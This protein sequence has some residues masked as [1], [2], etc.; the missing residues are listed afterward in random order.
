MLYTRAV[1][2]FNKK[3]HFN[4]DGEQLFD[5]VKYVMQRT[6]AERDAMFK[7]M[8]L[9]N[10]PEV[11]ERYE[12]WRQ[13]VR[14][15]AREA[16]MDIR[17]ELAIAE[18]SDINGFFA[19]YLNLVT[20]MIKDLDP[21]YQIKPFFGLSKEEVRELHQDAINSYTR[22]ESR[23]FQL[24][25]F[26]LKYC[27]RDI[28]LSRY[29]SVR[30]RV[31]KYSD[32]DQ[33]TRF[34][35]EETYISKLIVQERLES[36]G[37]FWKLFHPS[38][39]REMRNFIAAAEQALTDVEFTEEGKRAAEERYQL[40][41][42]YDDEREETLRRADEAF[43]R[44]QKQREAEQKALEQKPLEDQLFAIGFKPS[45]DEAVSQQQRDVFNKLN[46]E[47]KENPDK[48]PL[49]ARDVFRKNGNKLR[50]AKSVMEMRTQRQL[51][52]EE[53]ENLKQQMDEKIDDIERN[54]KEK[55]PGYEPFS[56]NSDP[57]AKKDAEPSEKKETEAQTKETQIK[58]KFSVELNDNPNVKIEPKKEEVSTKNSPV[59][60]R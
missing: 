47:I 51:N 20:V 54:M 38:E 52:E 10:F 44:V 39:T 49:D 22:R 50:L 19:G 32:D 29:D 24:R 45:L 27:M 41:A 3:N 31:K 1:E 21:N 13:E 8:I 7:R 4:L 6:G 26:G 42:A 57:Q 56:L 16:D 5:Q 11:A 43:D 40:G 12:P 35:I 9:F 34:N 23:E 60:E 58:V 25:Y 46:K 14:M 28:E 18:M 33:T 55:N 37:F 59:A 30:D 48:L 2:S 36:K 15:R 17:W 53:W